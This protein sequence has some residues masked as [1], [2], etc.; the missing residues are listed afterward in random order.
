MRC[1]ILVLMVMKY[2]YATAETS[3]AFQ[4]E[5]QDFE[6]N[7][8][9]ISSF[10]FSGVFLAFRIINRFRIGLPIL[11]RTLHC[12]YLNESLWWAG[13]EETPRVPPR[14]REEVQMWGVSQVLR[15]PCHAQ[16]NSSSFSYQSRNR[17]GTA[18][19]VT[20]CL[21]GTETGMHYGSGTGFGSG[22]NIKCTKKVLNNQKW[23][24]NFWEISCF[25]HWKG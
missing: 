21:S 19:T 10:F 14:G 24:A 2:F 22:F 25:W 11:S 8:H 17:T 18:G 7:Q 9:E 20:F 13:A 16:G 6:K 23:K 4:R 1:I 3:G 5:H 12:S 15:Y